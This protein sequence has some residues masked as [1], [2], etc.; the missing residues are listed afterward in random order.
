MAFAAEP[1]AIHYPEAAPGGE[2]PEMPV[3]YRS[4]VQVMVEFS[5]APA[6]VTYAEAYNEAR[7]ERAALEV[8]GNRP[9]ALTASGK[10][11]APIKISDAAA[12]RVESVVN[13][14]D[15]AQQ[16]LLPTLTGQMNGTVLYR[17]QRAYNGVAL[18]V[19]PDKVSEIASLPGVKAVHALSPKTLNAFSDLGFLGALGP[20]GAWNKSYDLG[21]GLHGEDLRI[22]VIDTGLDYV[23]TNFGGPGTAAA[24]AAVN[25]VTAPNAYF[26][27]AKVPNGTDLCGD[28]Y[29]ASG[30]GPALVPAPDPNPFDNINGHG[31]SCA[32]LAAGFGVNA[33]GTRYVGNYSDSTPIAS[34]KISPG[35]A[36][37]AKIY[38]V[39]IIG[40]GSTNLIVPAVDWAMNPANFGGTLPEVI[41]MS[42]GGQEG[43]TDDPDAV[44]FTNAS[45]AGILC[46]LS[47]GNSGNTYYIAGGPAIASG[48]LSVAATFNDQAG[49]VYDA[50]VTGNQPAAYAGVQSFGVRP[51]G[52][53]AIPPAGITG[54][55]VYARPADGGP[56][57]TPASTA[58]YT[59]A[60]Q[61]A[62]KICLVDRGGGVSFE[63]KAKR[64]EAS[65]AIA[66]IITNIPPN[67]PDDPP[68]N[69]GLFY[70]S[71]IPVVGI[72]QNAGNAMKA[73]AAFD[74]NGVSTST[75]PLNVTITS[76]NGTVAR[77]GTAADTIASYS[78]RGPR[79]NDNFLKPDIAA[80]A[81][82]VGVARTLTGSGVALF[83]GT[84][85]AAPH[86]GGIMV[87]LKQLH[88]TW[89]VAELNALVM[90]TAN[91]DIHTGPNTGQGGQQGVSRVGSGRVDIKA[92]IASNVIVYNTTAP[93]L[94]SLSYGSVDCITDGIPENTRVT[95]SVTFKNKGGMPVSY[96]LSYQDVTAASDG[97]FQTT[98][99]LN[100]TVPAN[101][102]VN[103]PIDFAATG[104]LMKH[105]RDST[106]PNAQQIS[107]TQLAARQWLTEKAG[108][109]VATPAAGSGQPVLRLAMHVVPRAAGAM[110]VVNPNPTPSGD[111]GSFTMQM[112]G[113]PVNTGSNFGTTAQPGQDVVGLVKPFELQYI[114]PLVGT[115]TP[116]NNPRQVKYVGVTSDWLPRAAGAGKIPTI[117]SFAT[118]TFADQNAPRFTSGAREIEIDIDGDQVANFILFATALTDPTVTGSANTNVYVTALFKAETNSSATTGFFTNGFPSNF[119][120]TNTFNN[121]V[122]V[123]HVTAASLKYD[124]G[125]TRFTY[126]VVTYDHLF[127]N[128]VDATPWL[129]YDIANPG[130]QTSG[131][132]FEPF[133]Y[134]DLPGANL[135][136]GYNGNNVRNFSN[137]TR[138]VMLVHMHNGRGNRIDTVAFTAPT[139]SSFTPTMGPVGTNVSINGSGFAPG[140]EVFFNNTQATDVTVFSSTNLQAKVPAGATDGP[141][142]VR[143]A[144][145]E[146]TSATPFDVTP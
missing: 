5:G 113:L 105:S 127:G 140:I 77:A 111:T 65:G 57:A 103:I 108:Y 85:S 49:F 55:V 107:A 4:D 32:S 21:V 35:F 40:A 48:V 135:P 70:N 47:A 100:F 134:N 126:R 3:K 104:H 56:A 93:N 64:A 90:N 37:H 69:V 118:E 34:M 141:I 71:T 72:S 16:A 50:I 22:V 26:P 115:A 13:S 78:S 146:D 73:A 138:G 76:G 129:T 131:P 42:I 46:T 15:A 92:A 84:S 130:F 80:P 144:G 38:P 2:S 87:L 39:R 14:L 95:K 75:P 136:M 88:P 94:V 82:I 145:G 7:M 125:P 142:K 106:V 89:S 86:V 110:H 44:A 60:A 124:G 109:L 11:Q 98:A 123:F 23:H 116:P 59:N 121:S 139:I 41:S 18:L 68:L 120:D 45:A 24:Y 119:R 10:S 54:D 1:Q 8:N 143:N 9:P 17:V 91:H 97:G 33:G 52:S 43:R 101:G 99:P 29:N 19:S 27:S 122:E 132:N 61:M 137:S 133:W 96:S 67:H 62:G 6:S 20:D 79:L 51:S 112:A 58:P 114:S 36:P 102:S 25:P 81:E 66:V 74:A 63:Q 31:T 28:T 30:T 117:I 53:A 12:V 128:E 83:N